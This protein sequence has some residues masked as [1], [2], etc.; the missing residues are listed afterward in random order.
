MPSGSTSPKA[1]APTARLFVALW[2]DAGVRAQL[3]ACRDAWRWPANAR[4]VAS[5]NLHATLHFIGSFPR[6]RIGALASR[7]AAVRAEAATLRS[8]GMEL[9]RGGIA[10]LTLQHEPRL[11]ALHQR[12]GEALR[13]S[14]I[15]LETRPF[16]PHVTL[17]RKATR[18][19]APSELP[20]FSWRATGFALVES[21]G[22]Q[23]PYAVLESWSAH[24][25]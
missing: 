21:R 18:A 13:A 7:L 14:G 24:V 8:K 10:V 3:A 4:P 5:G 25:V 11:L 6:E 12:V 15:A 9:W 23:A 20:P 19:V 2:P 16:T 17:A 1:E 22:G